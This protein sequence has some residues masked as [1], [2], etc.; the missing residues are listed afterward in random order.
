M[1]FGRT[2]AIV[3]L[4]SAGALCPACAFGQTIDEAT[5]K[6]NEY[7]KVLE[8]DAA[9]YEAKYLGEAESLM[10]WR[11]GWELLIHVSD[12]AFAIRVAKERVAAAAAR[13][14][15]LQDYAIRESS[16]APAPELAFIQDL[17]LI[18]LESASSILQSLESR[19]LRTCDIGSIASIAGEIST[20]S[21]LLRQS[22]NVAI[23]PIVRS[24]PILRLN[25]AIGTDGTVLIAPAPYQNEAQGEGKM[26]VPGIASTVSYYLVLT[27]MGEGAWLPASAIATFVYILADHAQWQYEQGKLADAVK[28][29]NSAI[30]RILAA[31]DAGFLFADKS[32]AKMG[33]D[34]CAGSFAPALNRLEGMRTAVAG[35]LKQTRRELA[36]VTSRIRPKSDADDWTKVECEI[37][38]CPEGIGYFTW[39]LDELTL[40]VQ[41]R[42]A[43]I[44]QP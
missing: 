3:F 16:I 15:I 43:E 34:M 10:R 4:V 9:H 2:L 32:K 44:N 33:V 24:D 21:V 18:D 25:F 19:G 22:P 27:L 40:E 5:D 37:F 8:G 36:S 31:Q 14:K 12:Q 6:I 39:T 30:D 26:A 35:E 13:T 28:R 1:R 11:V 42:N 38:R 29:M 20:D 7:A 23:Y 41:N 17:A